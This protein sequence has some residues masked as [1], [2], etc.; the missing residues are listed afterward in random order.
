MRNLKKISR[1]EKIIAR[2][3]IETTKQSENVTF[4]IPHLMRNPETLRKWI[5]AGV[6]PVPRYGAGIT[7]RY[8]ADLFVMLAMTAS[9]LL[10]AGFVTSNSVIASQQ[11]TEKPTSTLDLIKQSLQKPSQTDTSKNNIYPNK[12]TELLAKYAATQDK[13]T[14]S[15]ISKIES[16]S[17]Y[18]GYSSQRPGK[19][20]VVY[21]KDEKVEIR[22]DGKR[23]Y[24]SNK[25]WGNNSTGRTTEENASESYN[26]WDSVRHYQYGYTPLNRINKNGLLYLFHLNPDK[27]NYSYQWKYAEGYMLRGYFPGEDVRID[28]ELKKAKTISVEEKTEEINGSQCYIID[29]KTT[30]GSEYKLWIDPQHGYNIAKV[31]IKRAWPTFSRPEGYPDSPKGYSTM[32]LTDVRFKMIVDIWLPVE[33]NEKADYELTNGEYEKD[34]IHVKLTEYVL[35]PDHD[36]L[37]SFEPKFVRNGA[38][39]ELGLGV[40][41]TWRDGKVVD[42]DGNVINPATLK[43]K[44]LLGETLPS[45]AEFNVKLDAD[46]IKDK[47]ILVCFYDFTLSNDRIKQIAQ[48]VRDLKRNDIV[49]VGIQISKIEQNALDKLVRKN[50][51][52]FPV[53]MIEKK[54]EQTRL[55]WGAKLPLW[56]ILTD[57][58]HTV[59]AEGFSITVLEEKIRETENAK[60]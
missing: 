45:L 36:A 44:S 35:N 15:F 22:T 27:V 1:S 40:T 47:M 18:E 38:N 55:E 14:S 52:S 17:E 24:Y 8:I 5:P 32:E 57:K 56:M 33:G 7:R 46:V 26:V 60:L 51:I 2:S 37:G 4:V 39:V 41:Y 58:L 50:G 11:S 28:T 25:M 34:N 3:P 19:K 49:L 23:I 42:S 31:K 6:H 30:E 43:M 29:A 13:L 20:G 9:I 54:N 10:F 21:N 48:K 59:T 53:G 16:T 12:A